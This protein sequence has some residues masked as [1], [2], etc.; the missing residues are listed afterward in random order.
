MSDQTKLPDPGRALPA[1]KTCATCREFQKRCRWLFVK[2]DG[3][4]CRWAPS[5]FVRK[6]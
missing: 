1:G 2:P 6:S 4:E 3:T 5:R